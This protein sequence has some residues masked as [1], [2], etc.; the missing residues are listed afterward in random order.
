MVSTLR[1]ILLSSERS[2]FWRRNWGWRRSTQWQCKLVAQSSVSPSSMCSLNETNSRVMSLRFWT[3]RTKQS[4]VLSPSIKSF[5][6][7]MP[8]IWIATTRTSRFTCSR[9]NTK[10]IW[11]SRWPMLKVMMMSRMPSRRMLTTRQ[12]RWTTDRHQADPSQNSKDYNVYRCN[13]WV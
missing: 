6:M 7:P 5:M 3:R 11:T 4:R 12:E 13:G 2:S 8:P 9:L 1:T 10:L